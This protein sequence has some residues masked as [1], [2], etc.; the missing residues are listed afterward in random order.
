M[1]QQHSVSTAY[2][3]LQC[4]FF[5][6]C[7][8]KYFWFI[9]TSREWTP[10]YIRLPHVIIH[11]ATARHTISGVYTCKIEHIVYWPNKTIK[12]MICLTAH[13]CFYCYIKSTNT[14]VL[15]NFINLSATGH[16]VLGISYDFMSPAHKI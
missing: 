5:S 7:F 13:G 16:H 1:W 8:F 14:L 12:A 2:F 6:F 10:R 15:Y 9:L 11:Q 3:G 4:S